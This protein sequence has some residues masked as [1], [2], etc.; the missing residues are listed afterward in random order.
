MGAEILQEIQM[1]DHAGEFMNAVLRIVKDGG[2]LVADTSEYTH[3]N[4][5]ITP[6]FTM[7]FPDGSYLQEGS[8]CEEFKVICIERAKR[9]Q[10]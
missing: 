3:G 8:F 1:S 2:V 4:I 5:R 10:S 9:A 6:G 7:E